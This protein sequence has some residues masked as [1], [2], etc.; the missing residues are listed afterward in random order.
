MWRNGRELLAP[1]NI[2]CEPWRD[3]EEDSGRELEE[4]GG[5]A[6]T[7]SQVCRLATLLHIGSGSL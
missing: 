1:G 5:L 4:A 7:S 2:D 6:M 3:R